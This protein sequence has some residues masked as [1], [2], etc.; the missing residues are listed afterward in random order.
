M[1]K[2]ETTEENIIELRPDQLDHITGASGDI[3]G[4]FEIQGLMSDYNEA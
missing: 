4:N 3:L 1:G 2:I